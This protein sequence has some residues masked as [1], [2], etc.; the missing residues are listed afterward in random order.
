MIV[1]PV[2]A[3]AQRLYDP[4]ELEFSWKYWSDTS[5]WDYLIG[6]GK[7]LSFSC[8]PNL[9]SEGISLTNSHEIITTYCHNNKFLVLSFLSDTSMYYG[10]IRIRYGKSNNSSISNYMSTYSYVCGMYW[11][12]I[13]FENV[14]YDAT[15]DRIMIPIGI[16]ENGYHN[17]ICIDFS[18]DTRVAANEISDNKFDESKTR[19]YN[20]NG[21][22]IDPNSISDGILIKTDGK[23][24]IKI[25]K[26]NNT[27]EG[28]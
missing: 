14:V 9:S 13:D 5:S 17:A 10:G 22:Q 16:D 2:L 4:E 24:T 27:V 25:I 11:Y 20:A 18:V 23:K 26:Q 15:F 28:L 8:V 19:Y 6:N 1:F 12:D 21:Q 7:K 3:N